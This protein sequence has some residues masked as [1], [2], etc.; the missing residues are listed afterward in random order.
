MPPAAFNQCKMCHKTEAGGK[1]MG[2]SLFGVV[3]R[4]SGSLEGY[5]YSPAMVASGKTWDAAN[6]ST[7]L[8][9]PKAFV[10]GNK[11][12]FAGLKDPALV[13]AVV[14]YLVTLK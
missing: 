8:A 11:M 2:P 5:S 6:L 3:G 4:K 13:K 14:D 7:Y 1:S 9:D 12:A 10:P